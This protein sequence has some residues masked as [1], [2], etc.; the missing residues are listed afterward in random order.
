MQPA[1]DSFLPKFLLQHYDIAVTHLYE[2]RIPVSAY[3]VRCNGILYEPSCGEGQAGDGRVYVRIRS[4][5][6]GTETD[7]CRRRRRR[8]RARAGEGGRAKT[9]ERASRSVKSYQLRRGRRLRLGWDSL[10]ILC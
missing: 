4:R 2:E 5:E 1:L 3:C 8:R 9:A 6:G 7:K 10:P